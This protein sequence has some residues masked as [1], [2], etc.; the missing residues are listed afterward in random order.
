[1]TKTFDLSLS[2]PGP[3]RATITHKPPTLSLSAPQAGWIRWRFVAGD[4]RAS[5]RMSHLYM[6]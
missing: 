6:H 3:G 1:M 4:T 2:A 5:L